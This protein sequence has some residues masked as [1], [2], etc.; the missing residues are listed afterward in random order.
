M[1]SA[2]INKTV[3]EC[4]HTCYHHKNVT[5]NNDCCEEEHNHDCEQR[6]DIADTRETLL[7][8][9]SICLSTKYYRRN[10]MSRGKI[11]KC[12]HCDYET[13][14]PKQT[15]I[16]HI[17]AKHTAEKDKPFYCA[18]CDKGFAQAANYEKHMKNIHDETVKVTKTREQRK[19][20]MYVITMG[21]YL[22]S[23]KNT[24]ARVDYYRSNKHIK[25]DDIGKITYKDGKFLLQKDIHYDRKTGYIEF[26]AYTKADYEEF[27][28][29]A[30]EQCEKNKE[31]HKEKKNGNNKRR[32][33]KL[34]LKTY[35]I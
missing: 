32:V 12:P 31:K 22:P 34:I 18:C 4:N 17:N 5:D 20:Y 13:T 2:T 23:S 25:A 15:L 16:N 28:K 26:T 11:H 14:G 8:T 19:P 9:D 29:N 10:K 21:D 1:A 30:A 7:D 3:D 33:K 24:I 35:L 27:M 6:A